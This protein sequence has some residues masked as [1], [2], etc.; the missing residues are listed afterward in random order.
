MSTSPMNNM[1]Q[2]GQ[3]ASPNPFAMNA[4]GNP[5]PAPVTSPFGQQQNPFAM[6]NMGMNNL[7]AQ[8][9]QINLN[10]TQNP[11]GQPQSY[12]PSTMVNI[13]NKFNLYIL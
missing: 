9:Q 8:V 4:F 6:N 3:S 7:N 10:Q 1:G 13:L 12:P 11:F 5:S 2:M